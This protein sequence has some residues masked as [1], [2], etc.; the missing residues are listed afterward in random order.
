VEMFF[1][2]SGRRI[3]YFAARSKFVNASKGARKSGVA[4]WTCCFLAATRIGHLSYMSTWQQPHDSLA[5][6]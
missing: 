3:S 5:F 6:V 2:R 1:D 4:S